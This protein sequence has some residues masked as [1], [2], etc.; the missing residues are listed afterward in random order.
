MVD[1]EVEIEVAPSKAPTA[2]A[3]L[4]GGAITLSSS[5]A[6][7]SRSGRSKRMSLASKVFLG[8]LLL[9]IAVVGVVYRLWPERFQ[10]APQ[11]VV[12]P[13]PIPVVTAPTP[14]MIAEPEVPVVPEV[15][16]TKPEPSLLELAMPE[17][18]S[19]LEAMLSI[20]DAEQRASL[21]LDGSSKR[22]RMEDFESRQPILLMDPTSLVLV[23]ATVIQLP[24]GATILTQWE[25]QGGAL[26]DAAFRLELGRWKLDW[27]HFSRY[28]EEDWTRFIS[29][30]GL[31]EAEFRLLARRRQPGPSDL[32]GSL[33]LMLCAPMRKH[34]DE[35]G[36][37]AVM[38]PILLDSPAGNLLQAVFQRDQQGQPPFGASMAEIKPEGMVRVRVR[39]KRVPVDGLYVYQ[40]T[41]VLA[42]H[43]YDSRAVDNVPVKE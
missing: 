23:G 15:P 21:I 25:T 38:Q 24:E 11:Q 14:P 18:R 7:H 2:P 6:S 31:E 1:R 8:W 13:E 9:M 42:C 27:E 43:W 28:S 29:G 19:V 4:Q 30:S 36:F 40:I 35:A 17:C 37:Q 26:F 22:K 3:T 32:E 41:R 34:Q 12:T 33:G 10:T 16:A 20:T 39:V 5:R